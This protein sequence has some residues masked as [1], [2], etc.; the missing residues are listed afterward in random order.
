MIPKYPCFKQ[1]TKY[2]VHVVPQSTINTS[3]IVVVFC[4]LFNCSKKEIVE[5]L[6]QDVL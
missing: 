2:N 3:N 4:D 1:N 5:L 6:T